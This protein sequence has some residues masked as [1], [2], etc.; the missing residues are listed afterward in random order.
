MVALVSPSRGKVLLAIVSPVYPDN[1][2]IPEFQD[3]RCKHRNQ[4]TKDRS[5]PLCAP[6]A[7]LSGNG[8]GG[9]VRVGFGSA[10]LIV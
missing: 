5:G 8:V 6:D 2:H 1:A 10:T 7:G 3:D 9:G 4:Q